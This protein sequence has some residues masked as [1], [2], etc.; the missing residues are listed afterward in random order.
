MK[1]QFLDSSERRVQGLYEPQEADQ[2]F[3]TLKVKVELAVFNK[4]EGE[5]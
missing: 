2:S 4:K 3:W 1:S 5:T